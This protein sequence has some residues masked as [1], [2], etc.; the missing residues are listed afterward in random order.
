MV[1]KELITKLIE[2]GRKEDFAT[3]KTLFPPGEV[4]QK[5]SIMRRGFQLWYDIADSLTEEEIAALMKTFTI[6]EKTLKGWE[7][8]SVSPVIWLGIKLK[9]RKFEHLDEIREWVKKNGAHNSWLAQRW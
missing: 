9:E 5:G 3:L 4:E 7:A 6:A 2:I 8:G 1:D